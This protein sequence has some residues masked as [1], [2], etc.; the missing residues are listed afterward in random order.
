MNQVFL[1]VITIIGIS[2]EPTIDHVWHPIVFS[3]ERKCEQYLSTIEYNMSDHLQEI[4]DKGLPVVVTGSCLYVE[5]T[6]SL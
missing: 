2:S 3:S 1:A 4:A 5:D 6:R